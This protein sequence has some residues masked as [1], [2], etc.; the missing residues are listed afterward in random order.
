MSLQSLCTR[1][2]RLRAVY[3][4]WA[5]ESQIGLVESARLLDT[6][7]DEFDQARTVRSDDVPW[8]SGCGERLDRAVSGARDGIHGRCRPEV[9]G[10]T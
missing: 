8:C 5:A 4:H 6:A 2:Q 3:G 10:V 9:E 7:R 1:F